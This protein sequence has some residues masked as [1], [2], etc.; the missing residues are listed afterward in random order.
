MLLKPPIL[1][2]ADFDAVIYVRTSIF[3][4]AMLSDVSGLLALTNFGPQQC[5]YKGAS[6]PQIYGIDIKWPTP[7]TLHMASLDVV[8]FVSSHGENEF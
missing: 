7:C 8:Q 5:H 4:L 3:A 6:S 2:S 1:P